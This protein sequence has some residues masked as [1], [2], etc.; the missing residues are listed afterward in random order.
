[1][2]DLRGNAGQAEYWEAR[3]PEWI[4]AEDFTTLVA[5]SFGRRA[6]DGLG[7]DAGQRVLDVGCGTGPTTTEL[8]RR[9]APG[10]TVLGV[11]IAPSMLVAARTRAEK[12]GV[13]NVEFAVGDVETDDLGTGS[14]DA[15]FS[16]FGVMFFADPGAAFANIRTALREGGRLGFVCWQDV[17]ANEWML[18]PGS[19]AMSVTGEL[20]PM[21]GP[22]EPG[23]FSLSDPAHVEALLQ[24]A[25]FR[26][27][28][29][30]PHAEHVIVDEDRLGDWA[31]A[32]CRVGAVREALERTDDP[33]IQSDIRAAVRSALSER[34]VDGEL[35]LGTAA[36]VVTAEADVGPDR[37]HR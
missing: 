10:G 16:H 35:R 2:G 21:P 19:A 31:D 11:D 3:S 18:I 14:F 9:V 17:F 37:D 36:L 8:A 26:A 29:V 4:Q 27:I 15:V 28:D 34:V 1:M 5:A 33:A 7:L 32:S 30:V 24:G 20:P 23:P 25:G 13:G 6:M 22:G 12:E